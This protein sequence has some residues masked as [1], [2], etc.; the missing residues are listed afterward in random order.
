MRRTQNLILATVVVAAMTGCGAPTEPPNLDEQEAP[1]EQKVGTPV[2]SAR[3]LIAFFKR[4]GAVRVGDTIAHAFDVAPMPPRSFEITQLPS[5]FARPY[6]TRGWETAN[7]GFGLISYNGV[8]VASLYQK[9]N[10]DPDVLYEI[11]ELQEK[12]LRTIRN[13][14]VAGGKIRYWF[15]ET[16]AIEGGGP[17]KNAKGEPVSHRLMVCALQQGTKLNITVAMGDTVVLDALGANK[18]KAH[19]DTERIDAMFRQTPTT[20]SP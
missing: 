11:L 8:I 13:E 7:E 18:A 12:G 10:A 5:R 17:A 14:L 16:P 9:R 1:V 20:A 6:S 2:A 19:S 15:W 4:S 3:S